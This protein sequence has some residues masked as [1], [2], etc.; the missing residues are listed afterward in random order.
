MSERTSH[1]KNDQGPGQTTSNLGQLRWP[2][3][4]PQEVVGEFNAGSNGDPPPAPAALPNK[5]EPKRRAP[6]RR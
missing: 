6:R 1:G 2:E 3:G 4:F 5:G